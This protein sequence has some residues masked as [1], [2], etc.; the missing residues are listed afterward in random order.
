[1]SEITSSGLAARDLVSPPPLAQRIVEKLTTSPGLAA[2]TLSRV[3]GVNE[4]EVR[5]ALMD[6]RRDQRAFIRSGLWRLKKQQM[7]VPEMGLLDNQRNRR[8]VALVKLVT[9][10]LGGTQEDNETLAW[11]IVKTWEATK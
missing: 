5:R 1:M 8:W 7:L 3:L 6:L 2:V 4:D 11:K 10:E 9:D